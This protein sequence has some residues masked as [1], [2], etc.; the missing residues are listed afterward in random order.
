[1]LLAFKYLPVVQIILGWILSI[2]GL[3]LF[4]YN[5][6]IY[7]KFPSVS[8]EMKDPNAIFSTVFLKHKMEK[9]QADK[10]DPSSVKM[11][12]TEDALSDKIEKSSVKMLNT[13][14]EE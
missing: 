1:M 12:K 8:I 10:L 9:E 13:E 6:F 3:Y 5:V 4:L 14:E 2:I 11:L 7:I